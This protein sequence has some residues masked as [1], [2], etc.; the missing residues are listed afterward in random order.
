MG[1]VLWRTWNSKRRR[2][3]QCLIPPEFGQIHHRV[4]L[5][6]NY[7]IKINVVLKVRHVYSNYAKQDAF[8]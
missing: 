5:L 1:K 8:T 3:D 6:P 4:L 2:K 7:K